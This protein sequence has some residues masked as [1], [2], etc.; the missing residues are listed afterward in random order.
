MEGVE[1]E[2]FLQEASHVVKEQGFYMKEAIEKNSLRDALKHASNVICELRTSQLSPKNYYELYMQVFHELQHLSAFCNERGR[3]GRRMADL[4][5]SVQHAGNALARLYLLVT[6]GANYIKSGEAPAEGILRDMIELCKAV[7]HPMRGLFLRY[8]LIQMCKDKLPDTGSDYESDGGGN[9]DDAF[10]FLSDNLIESTRL[11]VRLQHQG[12]LNE[13]QRRER[14]RHDLRVL[15]GANLV[16]ISQ[17]NG[18]SQ[19]YYS[20]VALPKLLEHIIA[21]KDPMAQQYLLDCVV[22]VFSD[23]LHLATLDQLLAACLKVNVT[24]DLKPVIVNLMQRLVTFVQSDPDSIPQDVDVFQ[25]FNNHISELVLRPLTSN[26]APQQIQ[27][28]PSQGSKDSAQTPTSMAVASLLQLQ[29]AFLTFTL[30]LFPQKSEYVNSIL[31]VTCRLI[32]GLTHTDSGRQPI[33][34]TGMSALVQLLSLPLKAL[35]LSVMGLENYPRL[36]SYLNAETKIQVAAAMVRAVTEAGVW[37][38][39]PAAVA[40][41]FDFITPLTR[42]SETDRL[43]E[44]DAQVDDKSGYPYQARDA[45]VAEQQEVAKLVHAIK[46]PNLD[47]MFTMFNTARDAFAQGGALRITHT[48]PGLVF[49]SLRLAPAIARLEVE[50]SVSGG[51]VKPVKTGVKKVFFFVHKTCMDL[52]SCAAETALRLFLQA[53]VVADCVDRLQ[54]T[55]G[56]YEEICYEF[57]SQALQCYEE[58]IADGRAHLQALNVMVGTICA[59]IRCLGPEN[60]ETLRH[61]LAAHSTRLL[62]KPDQCRAVLQCTHLFWSNPQQRDG[63]R[64]LECLQKCLTIADGAIQ[65]SPSHVCLLVDILN[66]YI[67]FFEIGNTRV[68]LNFIT[69]LIALCCEHLSYTESGD[70]TVSM[71]ANTIAALKMKAKD[72]NKPQFKSLN[73]DE[74][75]KNT[76]FAKLVSPSA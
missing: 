37:L 11:W 27:P 31:S 7:Q 53:A 55:P 72:P 56:G 61:K 66:Q 2:R 32:D 65:A 15:V 69:N 63:V 23:E 38:D 10:K 73:V 49:A 59:S 30:T 42:R 75:L 46:T 62:K 16:R 33:E 39:D 6:V 70:E 29:V 25:L 60:T 4:Y 52:K 20:Q 22:Q 64:V 71:F 5:E 28:Q 48:Y 21:S 34:S 68:Q 58:D 8:Y 36:M 43:L 18:I 17:L 57:L 9:V 24:V 76:T 67:Y 14:E 40:K 41:F 13:R 51:E 50:A 19:Q 45:F 44:P 1:H 54:A 26:H 47:D 35:S 3:H 74:V 12:P